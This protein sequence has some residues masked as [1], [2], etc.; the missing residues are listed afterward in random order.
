[1]A[2]LALLTAV[3]AFVYARRVPTDVAA[4]RFSVP[5][6]RPATDIR[7]PAISPDGTQLAFVATTDG[8][9][10]IWVRP[11]K[12]LTAQPLA[13]TEGASLPFWSPDNRSIAFFADGKL[14]K[15]SLAGGPPSALADAPMGVG[16][17][18]SADG[19]IL[20]TPRLT[21][22]VHRVAET[23]GAVEEV[24]MPDRLRQEDS[25]Q[26]PSFLPDG[27]H[28]LYFAFGSQADAI[29]IY[30]ASLDG[31]E[32][33][34]LV[35]ADSKAIFASPGFLIYVRGTTLLA[36]PFSDTELRVAGEPVRLATS[37]PNNI[38]S[39]RETFSV[40]QNGVLVYAAGASRGS[41]QLGWFDRS[42]NALGIVGAPGTDLRA[43][44]SPDETRVA[45]SR[46]DRATQNSEIW[47][48]DLQRGTESRFTFDA[49]T[50]HEPIWS[51][52]SSRIVWN[53]NREGPANLYQK[54]AS[55]EGQDTLLLKADN[56][57]WADD[58]SRDGRF[59]VYN[60]NNPKSNNDLWILPLDGDRTAFAW[61]RM[62]FNEREA[63]ISSNS[64]WIAYTSD[65]SGTYDVYVEA[66][67]TGGKWRV[68]P[69]GGR[70]P[71]WR[72]DGKELFYVDG[73]GTLMS[74]DIKGETTFES[75][76]PKPLFHFRSITGNN[77]GNY[78]VTGDGQR[79]LLLTN[80]ED[81]VE[82]FSI[83]LNWTQELP[84]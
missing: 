63:R 10:T 31:R 43:A 83:V 72:R 84:R 36:Q 5:P 41:E 79:F 16:G 54:A 59:I 34:R 9:A 50:D 39:T 40:S 64:K 18:W 14:K 81:T 73:G 67:P 12:S 55:G 13:G 57:K 71:Q 24:T 60:E 48:I 74:V 44:L 25:H 3:G 19:T 75:G 27:R 69:R 45:V 15:I 30:V 35:S 78:A 26:W 82:P 56:W 38:F 80:P 8:T 61:R 29:G 4:I 22:G 58:W 51:P 23:G 21:T 7:D 46:L 1:V 28:F 37:M 2:A 6:P 76:V 47:L 53:S 62:P 42:G 49:A 32:R 65:E 68:S 77:V 20:F 66:F 33:Q 11:L 70:A 52:D 17:T